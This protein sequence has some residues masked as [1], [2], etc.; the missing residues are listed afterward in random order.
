MKST[1]HSKK[2]VV[3]SKIVDRLGSTFPVLL[4]KHVGDF[5]SYC[6][7]YIAL[8]IGL[9]KTMY[10]VNSNKICIKKLSND[11]LLAETVNTALTMMVQA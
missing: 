8:K 10:I 11:L 1:E 9:T 6:G 7:T 3:R 4:M 2:D 5:K